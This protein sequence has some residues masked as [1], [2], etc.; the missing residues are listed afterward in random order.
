M[1]EAPGA[2]ALDEH[3]REPRD[4]AD[5]VDHV[6]ASKVDGAGPEEQRAGRAASGVPPIGGP[7]PVGRYGVH[8]RRQE[9]GVDEVGDELDPLNDGARRNSCR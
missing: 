9:R 7:E 8:E 1:V 6:G 5:R 4:A 2:G 3:A